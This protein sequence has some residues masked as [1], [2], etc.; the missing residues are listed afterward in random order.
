MIICVPHRV[1]TIC[2]FESANN[3]VAA[4]NILKMIDEDQ[5]HNRTAGG[6]NNRNHLGGRLLRDADAE[7]RRNLSDQPY[8]GRG[9]F[10]DK[11]FLGNVLGSFRHHLG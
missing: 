9:A 7:S 2:A 10:L 6:T 4:A 1:L 8:D 3:K 11:A 5:V